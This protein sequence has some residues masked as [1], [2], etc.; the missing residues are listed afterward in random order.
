MESHGALLNNFEARSMALSSGG[1]DFSKT[2]LWG[3][4]SGS[5][6]ASD[7]WWQWLHSWLRTETSDERIPTASTIWQRSGSFLEPKTGDWLGCCVKR[8]KL[9]C[10]LWPCHL[11]PYS[12]LQSQQK[13]VRGLQI[14]IAGFD[15]VFRFYPIW[16]QFRYNPFLKSDCSIKCKKGENRLSSNYQLIENIQKCE[17][18]L[19]IYYFWQSFFTS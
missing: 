1:F 5:R 4:S 17:K 9:N 14:E 11:R 12:K 2:Y 7:C 3:P 13:I 18:W 6:V 10:G 19:L 16:L 15:F 8:S